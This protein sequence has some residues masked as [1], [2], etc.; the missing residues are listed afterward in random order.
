MSSTVYNLD[1][2]YWMVVIGT[3]IGFI[4][5]CGIGANDV[6]NAFA[7]TVASGSLT[8]KQAVIVAAIFEF[9]GSF[10]LGA[11]VTAT[12]R[13]KI[14]DP[15]LYTTEPE[16]VMLG[17][18]TSLV[19]AT[20]MLFIATYFA[21]PVSTTHTI[22]GC[23]MGFTIVAKGFD[24]VNW[25]VAKQIFISWIT[26]PLLSGVV[27]YAFFGLIRMFIMRHEN[28]YAR[29]FKLFP[30][31][32]LC[33][34]GLDLFFIFS[35][36]LGNNPKRP[37][38]VTFSKNLAMTL[39][40]AFGIGAFC[41][42]CWIYPLGPWAKRRVEANILAR[43]E[44]VAVPHAAR[45]ADEKKM[46]TPG[47]DEEAFAD[48]EVNDTSVH[49]SDANA[50]NANKNVAEQPQDVEGQAEEVDEVKRSKFGRAM[51][52]FSDMTYGQDL[53]TQ[54]FHESG[55]A[56]EIW[57]DGEVFDQYAEQLFTY[58]QVFTSCLNSFAHG[59][60]DVANAIGPISGL[61]EIYQTGQVASKA[62]VPKWI[63][64]YGGIGIVVGL[65]LYGYKVMKSLGYKMTILSP[66]RG[67]SAELAAS[68]FVVV[69]SYEGIPVSS[70]QAICGAVVGVGLAG[71]HKNV[72]WWFL[73]KVCCSWVVV[74]FGAVFL[75]AGLFAFIA[76]SPSIAAPT[77]GVM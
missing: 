24:S 3:I 4:Y 60:N 49:S 51:K 27:A 34:I 44:N 75:S 42:L 40:I 47:D 68:L 22:V 57:E 71:G 5:A 18:L 19:V 41:G 43:G 45:T 6:A 35:R 62:P 17:F 16:V 32:L 67:A 74:F 56:E 15:N 54:S 9:S 39:G 53:K 30:F 61:I 46:V 33:A 65:L 66:S 59:A 26:S 28:A 50:E 63:L 1:Q 38:L 10:F 36:G 12:V 21:M 48:D 64:A 14:F 11:T 8:L 76:L 77:V 23:I 20:F 52:S 58:I 70:T 55:R 13:S 69:A 29:V 2:Y 31:I 73:L 25:T 72:Q 37:K 7:S